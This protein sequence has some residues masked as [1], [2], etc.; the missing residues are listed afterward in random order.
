[1]LSRFEPRECRPVPKSSTRSPP[2]PPRLS[3]GTASSTRT[4][5]LVDDLGLDSLRALTSLVEIENRLHIRLTPDDEAGLVTVGD[6][7]TVIEK[8]L[9]AN[10]D[11]AR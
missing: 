4:P 2:S 9:A 3:T 5:T 11:G 1:M 7:L 10:V 6:L 8:R